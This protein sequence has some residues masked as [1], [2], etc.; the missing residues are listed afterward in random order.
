M[1]YGFKNNFQG[2]HARCGGRPCPLLTKNRP[3]RRVLHNGQCDS[4]ILDATVGFWSVHMIV[5]D[6]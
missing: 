4:G 2:G 6:R 1:R 5:S 3:K